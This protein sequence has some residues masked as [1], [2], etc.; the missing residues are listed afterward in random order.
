MQYFGEHCRSNCGFFLGNYKCDEECNTYACNFDGNDC[1]LGINPWRNCTAPIKCWE[2]FMDGY[3]NEVC[4]N[5][6]CL[7]DGRDCQEIIK[8]C[9]PLYDTYCLKHYA[10][11]HCDTGCNTAECNWD[12]LDCAQEPPEIAEGVISVVLLMD[13]ATL[14]SNLNAFLRDI[15]HQ[16]RTNVQVKRDN[17]GK[18]FFLKFFLEILQ[19]FSVLSKIVCMFFLKDW[20]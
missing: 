1:T 10:D 11:G 8:P 3:C 16:L 5:P 19:H 13:M 17:K 18:I 9:N 12:G 7:F 15:S 20:I 6:Q 2:V 14:R 4:N